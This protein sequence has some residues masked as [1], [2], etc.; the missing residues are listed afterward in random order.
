[1]NPF[2]KISDSLPSELNLSGATH[3]GLVRASNE[4]SFL[5]LEKKS[6]N[7]ML[8]GVADGMGGHEFGEVASYLVMRYMLDAWHKL[9]TNS[10]H[11]TDQAI[12]FLR[13][14]LEKSNQHIYHVNKELKIRWCMGTTV[15][16]GMLVGNQLVVAQI[17]DSRCYKVSRKKMSQ[18]T[19]DQSWQEE[20]VR[21]GIM[22][23]QAASNHP[24]SNMLTNCLGAKNALSVEFSID[25]VSEGDRYIFCSDGLN[26]MVDDE[27]ISKICQE[28]SN[29][30]KGVDELIKAA[31]RN[32]GS[33]NVTVLCLYL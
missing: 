13:F 27:I 5:C 24:L 21:N 17:G 11:N 9:P 22:S 26:S 7:A 16:M 30:Q 10:I 8:F 2:H 20:M 4:D 1:M 15:T 19:I 18:I 23:A 33:D 12:D 14:N 3:V 29:P 28:S 25:T 6:G 31:L 32:G